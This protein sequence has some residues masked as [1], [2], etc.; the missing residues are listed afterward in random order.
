MSEFNPYQPP[1][2]EV[3]GHPSGKKK[4]EGLATELMVEHLRATS[5][6]VLFLSILGFIIAGFS[7]LGGLG[8]MVMVPLAMTVDNQDGAAAGI[9]IIVVSGVFYLVLGVAYGIGAFFLVKYMQSIG[10][11]VRYGAASDVEDALAAQQRFWKTAGI[12]T[13]GLI[14]ASMLFFVAIMIVAVASAASDP[15]SGF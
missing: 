2:A 13:I 5:P 12:I 7:V 6:W 15:M 4:G 14:A 3:G 1:S 11:V 8:T 10:A 9:G